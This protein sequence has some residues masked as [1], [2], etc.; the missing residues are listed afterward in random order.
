MRPELQRRVQRYGWDYSSP[1]YEQGWQR[2]LLPAQQRLL[3]AAELSAGDRV[4][5]ISCGTGLVTLPLAEQVK[6]G[7]EVVG[8]DLSEGM[9]EKAAG[10]SSEKGVDNVS[11]EHMDAEDLDFEDGSFDAAVNSLGYMYYP[12]PDKAT[13][14]MFRV[15][16]SGGQASALVWGRRSEC[17][18]ASIFPIVDRRVKTDVCPLFF[19][20]GTGNNLVHT[21]EKA[22]FEEVTLDRFK[23]DMQFESEE[24]AI[25]GAF[26]GGAVA[27]AYRK[28]EEAD[29]EEAHAEYLESI[30]PYRKGEGYVIPGEF[31]VATAYKP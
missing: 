22:G 10:I 13:A 17:G 19:Q 12:E 23:V 20:L 6:P 3:D 1:Y 16:K 8:V 2:Q 30:E 27:M 21:F 25:I 31:V 15:V 11:Y 5:D 29:K 28:F 18:W 9:I 14:E 26:L 4:L 7:G 24:E